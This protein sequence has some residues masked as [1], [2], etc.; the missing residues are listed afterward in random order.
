MHDASMTNY[1]WL[2]VFTIL[3]LVYYNNSF[4]L[5]KVTLKFNMYNKYI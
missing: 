3:V 5:L 4:I 2:L 1:L